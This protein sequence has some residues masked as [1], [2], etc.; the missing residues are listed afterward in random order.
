MKEITIDA[1]RLYHDLQDHFGTANATI[2]WIA[3]TH[4]L[5]MALAELDTMAENDD[6]EGICEMAVNEG[7]DLS[8]YEI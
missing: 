5:N 8:R 1:P 7:F 3:S 2:P 4:W 6:W